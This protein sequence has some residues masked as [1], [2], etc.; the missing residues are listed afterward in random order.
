MTGNP[1]QGGIVGVP[2]PRAWFIWY[3][4]ACNQKADMDKLDLTLV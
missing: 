2:K 4:E 3:R 1:T